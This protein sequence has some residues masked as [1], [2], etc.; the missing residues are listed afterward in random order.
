MKLSR[1]F[2][3]P[4]IL[5][6]L[7]WINYDDKVIAV[8][9]EFGKE[10]QGFSLKLSTKRMKFEQEM[11]EPVTIV[12][13]NS[14][15]RS[16]LLPKTTVKSN[17]QYALHLVLADKSGQTSFFSRNLLT[18]KHD[19]IVTGAIPPNS[20]TEL[21]TVSFDSLEV[22]TVDE[23]EY[24][25]P[26][27]NPKKA[28]TKAGS[29]SPQIFTL[30]AVLLSGKKETRPDFAIASKSWQIMLL[31]KSAARMS[32]SEKQAKL[33]RYLAKMSEGAYGGIGVSSQLA[34]LGE[35]AVD[36]LIAM[37]EKI[38]P[39]QVRE[40]RIW[41]IVTLC[42]SGSPKAEDYIIKRISDPVDFGDLAFLVWHSQGFHSKRVTTVIKD[43][44]LAIVTDQE[45]P[46]EK[47]HGRAS[48]GHGRG[49]LEYI[50]KH[51]LSIHESVSDNI[52]T[53]SLTLEDPKLLS[54]ALQVWKP[55]SPQK[56][57]ELTKTI[58]LSLD[59]HPNVKTTVLK[60]LGKSLDKNGFPA[61]N[62]NL[63]LDESWHAAGMWLAEHQHLNDEQL[64][65]FL[66]A[67][68]LTV[69][70]NKTRLAVISQL[71]RHARDGF[72]VQTATPSLTT[73]WIRTW[74]W[75]LKT[76]NFTTKQ[77]T[78]FLC[79]QMRTR[80]GLD[81]E[82]K[83]AL[84]Q[85]FKRVLGNDFPLKSGTDINLERDWN[86]CGKWLVEKGFFGK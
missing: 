27:F 2:L 55:S 17:R 82:L 43:L 69:K 48:R 57:I 71:R 33:K 31:P 7:G 10:F 38:G 9:P 47:K 32:Q 63:E 54:F 59:T 75:A 83:C 25:M 20:T 62:R 86:T 73:D 81:P 56:A 52:M 50:F 68:V 4:A 19:I 18:D 78:T 42:N 13:R 44:A 77:T 3:L 40:S 61:Y 49:C 30:K 67:Q 8:K 66:L 85:E 26:S 39:T 65:R 41:A 28:M 5:A 70:Q 35:I 11:P 79:K 45:L 36:P 22:A 21:L 12:L 23:Y 14:S 1:L 58:F 72:P 46:W 16:T 51:F 24:G 29:M 76:G 60:R 53:G 34:A 74:Q 15:N 84:L 6:A 80:E 37:A 64:L